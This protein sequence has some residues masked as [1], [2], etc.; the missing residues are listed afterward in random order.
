MA[1]I[2]PP[3]R[4]C[5]KGSPPIRSSRKFWPPLRRL[6]NPHVEKAH[7][8]LLGISLC[9]YFT[10]VP[11]HGKFYMILVETIAVTHPGRYMSLIC[12]VVS[13]SLFHWDSRTF[14]SY[15]KAQGSW[16][17]PNQNSLSTIEFTKPLPIISPTHEHL[18]TLVSC[19][20]P[21]FQQH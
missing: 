20:F 14:I 1:A 12:M 11:K 3:W 6:C 19:P 15:S 21:L 8:D 2:S 4:L 9:E 17:P 5:W 18:P 13:Q 16:K 10:V 7:D